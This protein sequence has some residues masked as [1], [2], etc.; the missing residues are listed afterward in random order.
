[1]VWPP[2]YGTA[3]AA[4]R[5]YQRPPDREG[6]FSASQGNQA[7]GEFASN[8]RDLSAYTATWV[9]TPIYTWTTN[10]TAQQVFARWSEYAPEAADLVSPSFR[11][12]QVNW[13]SATILGDTLG[14]FI[15]SRPIGSVNW[16]AN[17]VYIEYTEAL[18][19]VKGSSLYRS[20]VNVVSADEYQPRSRYYWFD[21]GQEVSG[22]ILSGANATQI[23]PLRC[24]ELLSKANIAPFV[25]VV[26][27]TAIGFVEDV[28]RVLEERSIGQQAMG[29][30]AEARS[31]DSFGF[32]ETVARDP[33]DQRLHDNGFALGVR[34]YSYNFFI[35]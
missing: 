14:L 25:P 22:P 13:P 26:A 18:D 5:A 20:N 1:M 21:V 29:P 23:L 4:G 33:A 7:A 27:Y 32:A 8:V 12:N 15:Y 35:G 6:Y 10:P 3:A 11:L 2:R 16:R 28:V 34:S 30:L 9:A 19:A 17:P 24:G 31:G